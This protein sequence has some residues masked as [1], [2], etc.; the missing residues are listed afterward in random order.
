[1]V[2]GLCAK[3]VLFGCVRVR[4]LVKLGETLSVQDLHPGHGPEAD[5]GSGG[6]VRSRLGG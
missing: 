2:Q 1:M 6:A 4:S 5:R 3:V